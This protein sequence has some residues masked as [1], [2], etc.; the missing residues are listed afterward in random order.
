MFEQWITN[1]SFLTVVIIILLVRDEGRKVTAVLYQQVK[2]FSRDVHLKLT[3]IFGSL[4]KKKNPKHSNSSVL[5]REHDLL[6]EGLISLT[7]IDHINMWLELKEM[8][9]FATFLLQSLLTLLVG[10]S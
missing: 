10:S 6:A 9:L 2:Y 4:K 3:S 7:L 1:F 5:I 8:V